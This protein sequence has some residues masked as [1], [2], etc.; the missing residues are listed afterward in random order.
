MAMPF[1]VNVV[2]TDGSKA[3]FRQNPRIWKDTPQ[4]ATIPINTPKKL[5]LLTL[6]GGIFMDFNPADNT[7][8]SR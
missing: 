5:K 4:T 3:S 8:E 2:Y 1:D 7:W 6:D